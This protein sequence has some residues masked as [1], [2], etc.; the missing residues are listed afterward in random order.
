MATITVRRIDPTSWEPAYG[1]GQGSYISDIDAVAQIIAQRLKFLEG[2]W[3]EDLTIGLPFWQ[4]I[5]GFKGGGN[6]KQ[7]IDLLIQNQI[8]GTPFVL[9]VLNV[10]S[11]YDPNIRAY[12]FYGEVKTQ[13]GVVTV[14]NNMPTPPSRALPQ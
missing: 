2:E 11:S 8:L 7:N 10:Q 6:N 13:F 1:N 5:A 12:T 3:W 9:S 4:K 14:T